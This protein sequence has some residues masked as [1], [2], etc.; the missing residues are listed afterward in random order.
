MFDSTWRTVGGRAGGFPWTV[1]PLNSG[2]Y[3]SIGSSSES[4][5]RSTRIIRSVAVT[6]LELEAIWTFWST[7]RLPKASRKMTS[8][9][10]ARSSEM[11]GTVPSSTDNRRIARRSSRSR[12]VRPCACG[13]PAQAGGGPSAR[14]AIG[15][16]PSSAASSSAAAARMRRSWAVIGPSIIRVAAAAA[17]E[18]EG[19]P[20]RRGARR[21]RVQRVV[22]ADLDVLQVGAD[23]RVR[24]LPE[25]RAGLGREL[26]QLGAPAPAGRCPRSGCRG[27]AASKST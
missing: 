17:R 7:F 2:R 8:P 6:V 9:R 3:F 25:V 15:T 20:R 22:G 23:R 26:Q 5:P 18:P 24:G 12:S 11:P 4:L 1:I 10:C 27:N 14:D 19:R 13:S 21:D 16:D